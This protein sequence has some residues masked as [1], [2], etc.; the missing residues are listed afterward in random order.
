[1]PFSLY[2]V[3]QCCHTHC[4]SSPFLTTHN[5]DRQFVLVRMVVPG[6]TSVQTSSSGHETSLL[7]L[8]FILFV[9]G[10]YVLLCWCVPIMQ[11]KVVGKTHKRQDWPLEE[12]QHACLTTRTEHRGAQMNISTARNNAE[13]NSTLLFLKKEHYHHSD[14]CDGIKS[15]IKKF[16]LND[17]G[18]LIRVQ[19][20]S[21]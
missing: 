3:D 20:R 2:L 21:G 10:F 11:T 1:M 12:T 13:Q 15:L 16:F 19:H 6:S 17:C 7:R 14:V 4:A 18:C 8:F 5:N 9:L